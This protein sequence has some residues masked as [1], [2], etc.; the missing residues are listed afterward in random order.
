MRN[1][2]SNV[3]D[4]FCY[5]PGTGDGT[6]LQLGNLSKGLGVGPVKE[7]VWDCGLNLLRINTM[8]GLSLMFGS[9]AFS[10]SL[11]DMRKMQVWTFVAAFGLTRAESGAFKG[12]ALVFFI[13]AISTSN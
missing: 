2:W 13:S 6:Q 7:E 8:A 11:N 12:S 4:W 10:A 5:I 9:V 1:K 3:I